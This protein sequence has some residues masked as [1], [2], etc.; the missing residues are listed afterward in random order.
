VCSDD[1]GLG[2]ARAGAAGAG[3]GPRREHDHHGLLD[4]R[5]DRVRAAQAR[6]G[7][8]GA[9]GDPRGDHVVGERAH[10]H[11]PVP[12]GGRRG[13]PPQAR[14]PRRRLPPLQPDPVTARAR[15]EDLVA[16]SDLIRGVVR[17][18][19]FVCSFVRSFFSF[20]LLGH[21]SAAAA[22]AAAAVD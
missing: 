12:G 22:A 7:V 15:M 10:P 16:R 11:Q 21:R 1:R 8:V 14:P 9:A 6:E 4:A 20:F 2:D 13:L 5:D 3:A 17:I 18:Q 19:F